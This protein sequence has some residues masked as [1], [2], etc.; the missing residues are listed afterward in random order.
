MDKGWKTIAA[1]AVEGAIAS[2]LYLKFVRPLVLNWGARAEEREAGL[3]GDDIMPDANLQTTRAV[4][5]D[6]PPSA[7]WP[8]LVQ[9]GPRPRAGAYTYD[10]I[11][12]RLGI[13]IQNSDAIMPEFQHLEPGDWLGLNDKGQGLRVVALEPE[14]HLV[15]Q[16]EPQKSTWAFVLEPE[17][18]TGTRLL[19][20][21]RLKG[22]G[23]LWRAF[24]ALVMEPGSLVMERKMLLGIRE[25]AE[26]LFRRQLAEP[27][28]VP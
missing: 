3:A 27:T 25:R 11:E 13:D 4:S 10:W 24:M 9:M 19:S 12:R 16:W 1:F 15:V 6:A 8:W 14:R 22:S 20:R 2:A 26:K 23:P 28:A 18:A 7:V 21:N 17:G 5:I